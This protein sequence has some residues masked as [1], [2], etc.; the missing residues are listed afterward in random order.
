M[1]LINFIVDWR[2]DHCEVKVDSGE[3]DI[4]EE[5]HRRFMA[6]Y[7]TIEAGGVHGSK[8]KRTRTWGRPANFAKEITDFGQTVRQTISEDIKEKQLVH[9]KCNWFRA[10]NH[11]LED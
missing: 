5:D 9:P 6:A 10:H 3:I 7:P 11:I 4:F 2:E 1:H 8:E